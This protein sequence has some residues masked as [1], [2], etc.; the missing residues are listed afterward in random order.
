MTDRFTWVP[1]Y[2]EI[3]RVVLLG[4]EERQGE[5]IAFLEQLREQG[6]KV[7]PLTDQDDQGARSL[8]DEIDP[9]TFFGVFNRGIRNEQRIAIL[10]SDKRALQR[11]E[12]IA[13]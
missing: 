5:L 11:K 1:M 2:R 4:W 9:F 6:L 10:D 12:H 13:V 3:A 8:L 7:T